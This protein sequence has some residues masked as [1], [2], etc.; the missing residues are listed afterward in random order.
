M[1][2]S[3]Q[4]LHFTSFFN[5]SWFSAALLIGSSC[6]LQDYYEKGEYIIREGE[7]GDTFFIIAKGQVRTQVSEPGYNNGQRDWPQ[8]IIN[9]RSVVF[10]VVMRS[11][12]C[13]SDHRGLH[14]TSGNKD[15]DSRRLLRRKGPHQV[16]AHLPLEQGWPT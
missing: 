2:G 4:C 16:Q 9:E 15:T 13:D 14:R 12:D 6:L 10:P 5:T 3:G 7:E 8:T 1:S 11:G